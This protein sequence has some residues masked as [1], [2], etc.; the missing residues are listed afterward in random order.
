MM[1]CEH[2]FCP[3]I[4]YDVRTSQGEGPGPA[5]LCHL[6]VVVRKD[7]PLRTG[8]KFCTKELLIRVPVQPRPGSISSIRFIRLCVRTGMGAVTHGDDIL[9]PADCFCV[10]TLISPLAPAASD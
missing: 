2:I 1:K 6:P 5:G 10:L 3:L 8:I 7:P 9:I 4:C